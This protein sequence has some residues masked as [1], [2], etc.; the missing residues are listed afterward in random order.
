MQ[1]DQTIFTGAPEAQTASDDTAATPSA[2]TILAVDDDP[3]ILMN[4]AALLEDLGHQVFEAS[5]GQEALD[6]LARRP[7]IDLLITDH[8]MPGMTGSELIDA[9]R[10]LRPELS[11]I[12]ATGFSG[13]DVVSSRGLTRLNKPY[14]FAELQVAV[15]RSDD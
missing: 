5:S 15:S 10:A 6:Q 13:E 3:I 1:S 14:S 8:A 2:R 11:V 12:L 4:T 7:E 9:A